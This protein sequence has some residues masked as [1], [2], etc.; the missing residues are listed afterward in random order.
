[1]PTHTDGFDQSQL[2]TIFSVPYDLGRFSS[3]LICLTSVII[4]GI[5][6]CE[7]PAESQPLIS[8]SKLITSL[9]T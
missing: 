1:M 7:V 4:F 3:F 5:L 6:I 2:T 9:R 8:L